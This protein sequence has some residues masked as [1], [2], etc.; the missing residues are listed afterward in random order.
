M[1]LQIMQTLMVGQGEV[2]IGG[3]HS[4]VLLCRGF[5]FLLMAQKVVLTQKLAV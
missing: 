5:S 1:F 4:L 3:L 2:S